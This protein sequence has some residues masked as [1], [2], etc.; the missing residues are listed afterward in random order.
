MYLFFI[1]LSG[2]KSAAAARLLL[3]WSVCR[4]CI[5]QRVLYSLYSVQSTL[6]C[7]VR[8]DLLVTANHL[9]SCRQHIYRGNIEPLYVFSVDLVR[10][11]I[12][13]W[14]PTSAWRKW[15][16]IW[17]QYAYVVRCHFLWNRRFCIMG[18]TKK[19]YLL[20]WNGEYVS[21][22]L[23]EGKRSDGRSL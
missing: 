5:K 12:Y 23:S 8:S 13:I 14:V 3:I 10:C 19:K 18:Y 15:S 20:P 9:I 11:I 7:R 6:D 2:M 4:I 1:F 17:T 16:L 21:Q 22:Q